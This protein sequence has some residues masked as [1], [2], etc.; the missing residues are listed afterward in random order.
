MSLLAPVVGVHED[1]AEGR[2]V[3]DVDVVAKSDGLGRT[4]VSSKWVV[5]P[6][7][8]PNFAVRA[9]VAGAVGGCVWVAGVVAGAVGRARPFAN[10]DASLAFISLKRSRRD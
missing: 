6:I 5:P 4:G 1:V 10:H 8:C 7:A 2:E 3:S 9:C